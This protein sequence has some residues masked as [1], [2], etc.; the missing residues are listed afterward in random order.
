MMGIF[1]RDAAAQGMSMRRYLRE[2][3]IM[4]IQDH[5]RI[6]Q[7]EVTVGLQPGERP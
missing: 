1:K 4:G 5:I 3:G 6:R 7:S 2:N